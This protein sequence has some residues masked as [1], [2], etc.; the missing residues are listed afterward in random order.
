MESSFC[1]LILN[2][3]FRSSCMYSAFNRL[4]VL[5]RETRPIG[6]IIKFYSVCYII[7]NY[8]HLW[9]SPFHRHF[10]IFQPQFF[11]F[12]WRKQIKSHWK[13]FRL[14]EEKLKPRNTFSIGEYSTQNQNKTGSFH[15]PRFFAIPTNLTFQDFRN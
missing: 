3:H 10:E 9:K 4:I 13:M 5:I 11:I 6:E 15:L 8:L 7:S 2:C 1:V 12:L 14:S